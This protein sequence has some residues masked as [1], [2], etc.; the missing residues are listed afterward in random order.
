MENENVPAP[1]RPVEPPPPPP[2]PPAPAEKSLAGRFEAV[3]PGQPTSA[4]ITPDH[5][6][7]VTDTVK[8]DNWIAQL[9]E[10]ELAQQNAAHDL[11]LARYF[12]ISGKF[13]DMKGGTAEQNIATAMVKIQLGRAW[14]FN[15]A[16]AIRYI[17]FVNGKPS[18]ET[19]I[20]AS[21]L[22]QHGYD[23]DIEWI[24]D[25]VTHKDRWYQKCVGCRLWLKKLDGKVYVPLT[26][27]AGNQVT[28]E[29]TEFDADTAQVYEK[30]GWIP[31][32]QKQNYKSWG[33]DMYFWRAI[34]RVKKYH[35]PHVLRGAI[36]REE[37]LEMI[38]GD[39]PEQ[40]PAGTNASERETS[41]GERETLRDRILKQ[42]PTFEM[43][44]DEPQEK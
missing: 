30:G 8:R 2:P 1:P 9:V 43:L 22:Q 34:S 39:P 21:K 28:V 25:K 10:I 19:E 27:R 15:A 11:K 40:L 33:R 3:Q 42:E 17:Y 36:E 5:L 31:L 14:G 13:D 38:P 26:D 41:A 23:W 37:A 12:A 7:L 35:A 24:E 18:L 4:R 32:S 29:F 20:I 16:D 6:A 44:Q